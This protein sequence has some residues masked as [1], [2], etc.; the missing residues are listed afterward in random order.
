MNCSACGKANVDGVLFCEYCGASMR[1]QSAAVPGAFAPA[2]VPA[3]PAPPTAAQVAQMGKSIIG[4]MT[5]GEKFAVAGVA[6]AVLGFFLP[7]ATTP[8]LGE[9]S[10]LLSSLGSG[11]GE[12]GHLS[13][14]LFGATKFL[15]AIYILLLAAVAAGV[16]AYLM[17]K[18]PNAKK[19]LM[20]GFLVMIGS[21][22]GPG[23]VAALL[24][25][26][27]IQSVAG[28]GYYLFGLGYCAI[29]A[30]GLIISAL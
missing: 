21:L 28:A 4:A 10:G 13:L 12:G 29:A 9:L 16:L 27:M 2:T 14:S 25:V 3:S 5:L 15:G 20:S 19:M 11:G 18:A 26:P 17:R 22:F 8:D 23:C 24:F 7:F 6:A 1:A 30:G